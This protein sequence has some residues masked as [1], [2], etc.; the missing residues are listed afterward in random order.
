MASA[1]EVFVECLVTITP[2]NEPRAQRKGLG[3]EDTYSDLTGSWLCWPSHPS[4]KPASQQA[5]KEINGK[6]T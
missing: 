5:I 4:I 1:Q 6:G 3:V 2:L